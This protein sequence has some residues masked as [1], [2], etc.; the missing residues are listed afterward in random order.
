[1][2]KLVLESIDLIILTVTNWTGCFC[3]AP[4]ENSALRLV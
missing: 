1:M 3:G 2:I 4:C